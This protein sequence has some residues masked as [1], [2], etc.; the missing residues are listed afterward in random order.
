MATQ[1]LAFLQLFSGSRTM[2]LIIERGNTPLQFLPELCRSLLGIFRQVDADLL[3]YLLLFFV[4]DLDI[5]RGFP[6]ALR[7]KHFWASVKSLFPS[8][9]KPIGCSLIKPEHL[10][11]HFGGVAFE[12]DSIALRRIVVW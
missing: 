2:F 12:L 6:M 10:I 4:G 8:F 3:D 9:Q 7:G 11:D 1:M 5:L